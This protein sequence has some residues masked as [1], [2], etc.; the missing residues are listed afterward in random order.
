MIVKIGGCNGSG[1]TTLMRSL[2]DTWA[3]TRVTNTAVG[4]KAVEYHA[5]V[6]ST[7]SLGR[8]FNKVVVLGNYATV[9]GGMDTISDKAVRLAMVAQYTR[10]R[11]TLVLY[12]GLITGKTYGAMG[13]L[14][15]AKGGVP[16]LYVFMDT[17]F[18]V[19]VQRVLQR[20]AAKGNLA[21]F[22]PERTMRPTFGGVQSVQRRAAAAGHRVW[23]ANHTHTAARQAKALCAQIEELA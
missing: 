21:P 2:M 18:E 9:C 15:D 23:L 6:S 1:K 10:Q 17:P 20:R 11:R 22:D 13:A 14:S 19:C 5:K 4:L 7:E 8:A 12:E 16:W 3:F